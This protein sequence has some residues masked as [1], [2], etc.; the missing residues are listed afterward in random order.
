M[1]AAPGGFSFGGAGG[2]GGIRGT[3]GTL[4]AAGGFKD[5]G[6]SGGGGAIDSGSADVSES[7]SGVSADAPI[8]EAGAASTEGSPDGKADR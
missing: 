3:G 8:F 4:Y 2:S 7:E 5:A 6:S 1:Y